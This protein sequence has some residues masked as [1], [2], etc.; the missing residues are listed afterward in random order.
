MKTKHRRNG[1][2]TP[3]GHLADFPYGFWQF[4]MSASLR[5][6]IRCLANLNLPF[7]GRQWPT[8][9]AGTPSKRDLKV[10]TTKCGLTTRQWLL[11]S[12][13]PPTL[14]RF[15]KE[16]DSNTTSPHGHTVIK[17]FNL[18]YFKSLFCIFLFVFLFLNAFSNLVTTL[19]CQHIPQVLF[20]FGLP[21]CNKLSNHIFKFTSFKKVLYLLHR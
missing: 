9:V 13:A 20:D 18:K 6:V 17:Y 10:D 7:P 11:H 12:P 5:P 4:W 21:S 14:Q 15:L 16:Y 3:T 19:G 2:V 8:W 1:K